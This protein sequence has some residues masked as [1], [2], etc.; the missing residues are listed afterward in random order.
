M[1]SLKDNPGR[2]R[3]GRNHF[4]R[5]IRRPCV[6]L[7]VISLW[8]FGRYVHEIDLCGPSVEG[9]RWHAFGVL[10]PG[11]PASVGGCPRHPR[12]VHSRWPD[13][14]LRRLNWDSLH[15]RYW[16]RGYTRRG[17]Y[18]CNSVVHGRTCSLV[19]DLVWSGAAALYESFLLVYGLYVQVVIC[20]SDRCNV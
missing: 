1:L 10:C 8:S 20:S 5:C 15:S 13:V 12:F 2:T 6:E 18:W 19:A 7:V 4:A 11:P 17:N 16:K 3:T 14:G 9:G